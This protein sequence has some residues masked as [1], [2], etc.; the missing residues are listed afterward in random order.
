MHF[1]SLSVRAENRCND[2][3]SLTSHNRDGLPGMFT[4]NTLFHCI[5]SSIICNA[6][7]KSDNLV[8]GE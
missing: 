4:N 1:Q 6:S 2:A 8:K 5:T 7:L 3:K